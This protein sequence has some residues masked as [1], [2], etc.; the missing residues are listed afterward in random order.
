MKIKPG[1][2]PPKFHAQHSLLPETGLRASQLDMPLYYT[3]KPCARGH[4]S[5][6]YTSSSNCIEC[7]EQ[8]RKIAGKN[9]RGGAKFRSQAQN[10]LAMQAL[11]NGQKTYIGNPCPIGHVERRASTGNCIVCETENNRKRKERYKLNRV[12]NLYGLTQSALEAM[13][14]AQSNQ[15]DICL[16][17]FSE[18][19]MH[20]DHCHSTNKVRSLLCSRCNQAIGLIDESIER[21]DKIKQYLQRYN[22]AS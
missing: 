13:I 7:I 6:R 12:F 5:P 10:E 9:M 1:P 3:G 8:K 16:A 19:N 20:I 2:K 22:H 18:V 17:S 15:C 11:A 4:Y 21:A 14:S